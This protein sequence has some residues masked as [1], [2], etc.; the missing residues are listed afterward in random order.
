MTWPVLLGLLGLALLAWGV[1]ALRTELGAMV[2]QRRG[3]IALYTLGV[4]GVLV[5]LAYLSVRLSRARRHDDDRAVLAVRA[6]RSRCSSGWK[7]RCM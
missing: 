3:E 6:R 2:R 5:A 1:F 7:S 4:I